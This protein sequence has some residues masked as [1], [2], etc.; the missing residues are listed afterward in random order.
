MPSRL[1]ATDAQ[2]IE[3]YDRLQNVWR[4]A[5][6]FGMCGQSVHERVVKLGIVNL[7][8]VFGDADRA[9][10]RAEYESHVNIGTLDVFSRID[11]PHAP[12]SSAAGEGVRAYKPQPP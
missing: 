3:S 11:G 1:K 6:E 8:N 12:V 9:R 2:I 4:V 7:M 10:L 5:D